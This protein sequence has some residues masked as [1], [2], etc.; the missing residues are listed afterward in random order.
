VVNTENPTYIYEVWDSFNDLV[1]VIDERGI[2][3]IVRDDEEKK[4]MRIPEEW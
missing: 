2:K 1:S 4:W 3:I